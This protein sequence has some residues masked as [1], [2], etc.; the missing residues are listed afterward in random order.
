MSGLDNYG[1]VDDTILGLLEAISS[2][3]DG[4]GIKFNHYSF[5]AEA[6]NAQLRDFE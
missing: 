4:S 3:Q 1:W 5:I 2:S 6:I